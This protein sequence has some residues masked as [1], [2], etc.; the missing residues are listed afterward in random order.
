MSLTEAEKKEADRIY[1]RIGN[2]RKMTLEKYKTN[3]VLYVTCYHFR[4]LERIDNWLKLRKI[5][6]LDSRFL[7][8]KIKFTQL[9]HKKHNIPACDYD[10]KSSCCCKKIEE[11]YHENN[12]HPMIFNTELKPELLTDEMLSKNTNYDSRVV[13][14]QVLFDD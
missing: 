13:L 9:Y 2:F 11:H 1:D 8:M 7:E 10:G 3:R 14:M 5:V 4:D 12:S 6:K